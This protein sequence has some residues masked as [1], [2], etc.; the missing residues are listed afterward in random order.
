MQCTFVLRLASQTYMFFLSGMQDTT[1]TQSLIMFPEGLFFNLSFQRS[2][3]FLYIYSSYACGIS[4]MFI[5]P[6]KM[7]HV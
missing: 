5:Y 1:L 6:K 7:P 2:F 4:F 3:Q